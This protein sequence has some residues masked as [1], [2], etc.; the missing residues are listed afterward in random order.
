MPIYFIFHFLF[1]FPAELWMLMLRQKQDFIG[2]ASGSKMKRPREAFCYQIPLILPV[3]TFITAEGMLPKSDFTLESAR[4]RHWSC[5][6][7]KTVGRRQ[8]SIQVMACERGKRLREKENGF[9]LLPKS[10]PK[11]LG[12]WGR[13]GQPHSPA[14]LFPTITFQ[15]VFSCHMGKRE[16]FPPKHCKACPVI[17]ASSLLFYTAGKKLQPNCSW[18]GSVP[19]SSS[20]ASPNCTTVIFLWPTFSPVIMCCCLENKVL[21][22]RTT[23][24]H[25]FAEFVEQWESPDLYLSVTTLMML[26]ISAWRVVSANIIRRDKKALLPPFLDPLEV[27]AFQ[28]EMLTFISKSNSSCSALQFC[29]KWNISS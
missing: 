17:P 26:I 8:N 25:M 15:T 12:R 23:L 20:W 14:L 5:N 6:R 22:Q 24:W 21:G 18:A 11:L 4:I 27:L 7:R 13:W 19:L 16:R 2:T 9:V 3:V 1:F 10:S 28:V 29:P